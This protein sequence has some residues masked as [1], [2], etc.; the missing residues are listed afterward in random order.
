MSKMK[1]QCNKENLG[2][3]K[4]TDVVDME[5]VGHEYIYQGIRYQKYYCPKCKKIKHKVI[6]EIIES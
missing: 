4:K 3:V 5:K 6:K 1:C 2:I